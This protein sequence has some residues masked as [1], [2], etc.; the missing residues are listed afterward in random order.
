M[1]KTTTPRQ[2]HNQAMQLAEKAY[3]ARLRGKRA[4]AEIYASEALRLEALAARALPPTPESEPTRSILFRS[5]AWLALQA[6][7]YDQ[8]L[9]LAQEGLSSSHLPPDLAQQ[10][11]EV[12]EQAQFH[13]FL[14]Q[15]GLSLSDQEATIYL[16]GPAVGPGHVFY[17]DFQERISAFLTLLQR[18]VER[19]ERRH[20]RRSGR[21]AGLRF[22]SILALAPP[23][24]FGFTIQLVT[25]SQ[26]QSSLLASETEVIDEVLISLNLAA[27]G[28]IEALRER[29]LSTH[30]H[31]QAQAY[32]RNFLSHARRIAPDGHR[33][34]QVGIRSRSHQV[35][36]NEETPHILRQAL[37]I[38]MAPE[39]TEEQ[40]TPITVEGELVQA[41]KDAHTVSLKAEDKRYTFEVR[42]GLEDMVRAYF[43]ERVQVR[44]FERQS[45]RKILLTEVSPLPGSNPPSS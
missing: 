26:T 16:K 20:Y 45:Q 2:L 38:A 12:Q 8:A 35:V 41:D 32:L 23:G 4:Q 28:S 24:S 1:S 10:L 43:G 25:P 34:R 9:R 30:D 19:F 22:A 14:E 27:Q 17:T 13:L 7:R 6:N 18:T 11:H 21:P 5:A 39:A 15:E 37:D 36:L 40:L 42:E 44:G 31:D 29:F 33:L 3:L